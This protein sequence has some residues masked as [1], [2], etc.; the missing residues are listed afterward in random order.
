MISIETADIILVNVLLKTY[1][2]TYLKTKINVKEQSKR[3]ITDGLHITDSVSLWAPHAI[4]NNQEYFSSVVPAA[5]VFGTSGSD[6]KAPLNPPP[7]YHTTLM[8]EGPV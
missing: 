8:F 2:K 3:A 1:F 4:L 6:F 7:L 5:I